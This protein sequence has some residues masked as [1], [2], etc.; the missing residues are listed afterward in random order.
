A[1]HDQLVPL[2]VISPIHMD[3]ISPQ[4]VG[5][6]IILRGTPQLENFPQAKNAFL[7]AAQTW[8]AVI[9]SPITLIIDVD[10]G[11]TR[12]GVPYPDPNIL[13][14]NGS[15]DIEN[16]SIYPA[17][18]SKLVSGASSARE[19]TLYNALPDGAVQTDIGSTAAVK[20][21]S[22][23][24]RALGLIGAVADPASETANLG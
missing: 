16:T 15:K 6:K 7:R 5:L 22:A 19:S 2:R 18:R 10:Y 3:G 8:E 11:P 23:V 9:Q 12:F 20:A 1:E 13:G 17:V 24:F 21:P 4:D 14:S